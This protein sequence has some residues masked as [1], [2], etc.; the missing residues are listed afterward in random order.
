MKDKTYENSTDISELALTGGSA[1][2][3][4]TLE[5]MR[6]PAAVSDLT[7]L[8]GLTQAAKGATRFLENLQQTSPAKPAASQGAKPN[9]LSAFK[10]A[11]HTG[12][13]KTAD[14]G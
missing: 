4:R 12:K 13:E 9:P 1:A 6:K 10:T 11:L 2:L 3:L 5:L 8:S 7:D 14:A